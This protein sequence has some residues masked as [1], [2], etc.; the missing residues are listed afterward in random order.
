LEAQH[1]LAVRCILSKGTKKDVTEGIEWYR[2]AAAQ[3]W[4]ES[5]DVTPS[6]NA[7]FVHESDEYSAQ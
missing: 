4:Q 5:I 7:V 6:R 3:G 2:K 1:D